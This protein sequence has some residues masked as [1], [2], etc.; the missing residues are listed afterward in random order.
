MSETKAHLVEGAPQ[1]EERVEAP[2]SPVLLEVVVAEDTPHAVGVKRFPALMGSAPNP[3]YHF[4]RYPHA[5]D[6]ARHGHPPAAA[7]GVTVLISP[8]PEKSNWTC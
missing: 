1:L 6:L 7:V 4:V 3:Y 5:A 8:R 2:I